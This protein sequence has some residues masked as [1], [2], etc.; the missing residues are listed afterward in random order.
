MRL[1]LIVFRLA[2]LVVSVAAG[3]GAWEGGRG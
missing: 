1:S 2:F 3:T